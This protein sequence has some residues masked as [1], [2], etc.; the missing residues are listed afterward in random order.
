MEKRMEVEKVS[1]LLEEAN[2]LIYSIRAKHHD[3]INHLQVI[4]GL[5]QLGNNEE[6][7]RYIKN[8]SNEL[9]EYE[10]LV[11][12]K[13]PEVA[14]LICSK[15]ASLSYLRVYLDITTSLENLEISPFPLVTVLGNLIDN[16]VYEISTKD[17][18][19]IKI[20]IYE[21]PKYFVFEITNPGVIPQEIRSRIFDL[22][23]TT[24]EEKDGGRGLYIAEKIITNSEG[25]LFVDLLKE[26]ET[27]FIVKLPKCIKK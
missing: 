24:K 18:K 21:D 12:L 16:A 3:F 11:S 1:L 25:M 5:A 26:N 17:D 13:R 7:S 6:V 14:A 2:N 9:I 23:F 10:K 19:W 8:L 15:T 20:A 27:T 4:M 22:G